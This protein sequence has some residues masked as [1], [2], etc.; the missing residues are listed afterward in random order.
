METAVIYARYS[1]ENQSEQSIDGQLRVCQEFALGKGIVV[2][3]TYID[4]AMTGTNDNRPDF[5][6]MIKDSHKK[7][8]KYVIVYKLDRFSRNK[9]EMAMHKK[10]LKD[11]GIKLISATEYI[12]DS[13][14]AIIIESMLEGYA[15][16]YSAELSQKVRR[17]MKETRLK[18]NYT[19]GTVL[20]GYRIENKKVV[21][22]EEQAEIIRLI[23]S[24]YAS[25]VFVKYIVQELNEMKVLHRGKPFARTTIYNI[26]GNEKYTG[27]YRYKGEVFDNIYPRI[28]SQEIFDIVRAKADK[29]KHGRH[30]KD[31]TIYLLSNKMICGYCGCSVTAESGTSHTGRVLRYY[32]CLGRKL[33]NGCTKENIQKEKL[34]EIVID[35]IIQSLSRPHVKDLLVAQLMQKQREENEHSAK[36]ELLRKEKRQIDTALA[37][38]MK[39]IEAGVVNRTTQARMQELEEQQ[40]EIEKHM[41]IEKNRMLIEIP[42]NKIREYYEKALR[43]EPVLLAA[44]LIQ[45]VVLFDDRVQIY[46]NSP[47]LC[48]SDENR[49][50]FFY[51]CDRAYT[52]PYYNSILKVAIIA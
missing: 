36:Y 9:Y 37:N 47:L 14:E 41:A 26:L 24:R 20:Y 15:E 19:G 43:L 21:I 38:V 46:I 50:C 32:K 2:V 52:V 28:V 34:E 42:E 45:K 22:V 44:C 39:A 51:M 7:A 12:P 13:P 40:A 6:R 18:G 27:I 4:R 16:Y 49:D 29:Q 10:T 8:W 31:D 17:G 5:Q 48:G 23:F 33:H 30:P 25:G 3:D 11:N 35:A 1:S